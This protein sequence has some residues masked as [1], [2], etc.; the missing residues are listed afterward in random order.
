MTRFILI[1]VTLALGICTGIFL[2]TNTG[3]MKK[4]A[5]AA[6]VGTVSVGSAAG[7]STTGADLES[8]LK[9]ALPVSEYTCLVYHYSDVITEKKAIYTVEG[10]VIFGFNG[11][12]IKIDLSDAII[13]V[14]IPSIKIVSHEILPDSLYL[15]DE[16]PGLFNRYTRNDA[17]TIIMNHK[18]EK[19]RTVRESLSLFNQAKESTERQFRA[20]LENLS[21]IQ[22]KYRIIFEWK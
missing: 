20:L 6:G 3:I 21:A 2:S 18:A 7:A 12:D 15:Y 10:T 14:Q 17:Q 4:T 22:G 1:F 11:D 8:A 9:Q 16:S 19:E 13:I 5:G